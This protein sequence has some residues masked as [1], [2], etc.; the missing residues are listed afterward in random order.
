MKSIAIITARGGSKRIPRKNIKDFC[1]KPIIAYSIEAAL[2]SGVFDAVMVSTDDKEIASI[3][4]KYGADV[5]FLRSKEN[6]SD[7][8]TTADVIYEVLDEYRSRGITFDFFACVYPTAPFLNAEILYE[9]MNSLIKDEADAVISVVKYNFPPQRSF[10]IRNKR[11][12]YQFPEFERVRSQDLEPIFHDCGQ[13]YMCKCNKFCEY[14]SLILPKTVPYFISEENVQDIDTISDWKIAE[15]K[16]M[17]FSK[18][19][20]D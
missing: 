9:A 19:A 6:S 7:Y 1:G 16:Y 15:A 4:K 12:G 17:F 13:F 14:K 3:A 5:P 11:I 8:A 2:Q 20:G 18:K 10:V